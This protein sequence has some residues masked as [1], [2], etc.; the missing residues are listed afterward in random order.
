[1]KPGFQ[2]AALAKTTPAEWAVRFVLGGIITVCTGLVAHAY[3]PAA[4]GLFL[5][6]PAI[7]PASLTLVEEH[8]GRGE[9]ADDARG[10]RLG[11]VGLLAFAAV[12][13]LAGARWPA[14][15][16]LGTA[17]AAWAVACGLAWWMVYARDAA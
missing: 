9:A 12:V 5:A 4:G 16:V 7:L 15:A 3:G 14:P 17:T 6:F 2:P 10:A 8:G 11:T 13:W 1:V